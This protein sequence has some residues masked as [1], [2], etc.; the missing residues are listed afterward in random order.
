MPDVQ[1]A[2]PAPG[3]EGVARNDAPGRA[4]RVLVCDDERLVLVMLAA[5]LRDAGY[6]VIEAESAEE[7]IELARAQAPELA[8]LD[9]RMTGMSGLEVAARFRD[10]LSIPFVFLSAF[11]DADSRRRAHAL[12]AIAYL[13]KPVDIATL[14]SIV[15]AA[16][17]GSAPR[18]A[19]PG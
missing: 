12:G 19:G 9:I 3:G 1:D 5:A 10:E 8:L 17:S 14:A 2:A 13:V 7:A 11:N 15:S 18:R 4:A 16:L 6:E